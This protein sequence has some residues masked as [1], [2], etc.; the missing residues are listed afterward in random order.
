MITRFLP[1]WRR[2]GVAA[3]GLVLAAC[4]TPANEDNA[5]APQIF[6]DRGNFEVGITTLN[7]SDRK[8]E[9][10]YPSRTRRRSRQDE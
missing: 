10:Y 3:L 8:I 2:Q 1:G 5:G 7:L 4:A 9:V 6:T